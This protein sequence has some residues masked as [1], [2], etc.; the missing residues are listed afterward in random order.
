[1][2]VLLT[3]SSG[4]LGRFLAPR[5]ADAKMALADPAHVEVPILTIALDAGFNSPGPF[6]R[7]CK[8]ETGMTQRVPPAP[9]SCRGAG[10]RFPENG[11]P[12]FKSVMTD[13]H[14]TR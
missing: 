3:G 11:K 10:A 4:W 6:N 9:P 8:A 13:N 7:A 12:N 5:I 2:R 1:M 14:P